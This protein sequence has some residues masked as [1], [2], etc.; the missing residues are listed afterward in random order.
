[1]APIPTKKGVAMEVE[2][3]HTDRCGG[4]ELSRQVAVAEVSKPTGLA[5]RWREKQIS[6]SFGP[7]IS[8]VLE[9]L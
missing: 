8:P 4:E 7:F 2:R 6:G 5:V 9:L 1:M 3:Q